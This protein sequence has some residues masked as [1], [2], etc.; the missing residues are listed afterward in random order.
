MILKKAILLVF[1]TLLIWSAF[2]QFDRSKQSYGEMWLG[3]VSKNS[4]GGFISGIYGK[5]GRKFGEKQYESFGLDFNNIKHQSEERVV[6]YSGNLWYVYRKK[7][8]LYTIVPYYGRD[9]ILFDKAAEQGIEIK[10]NL[11]AGPAI[12]LLAPYYIERLYANGNILTSYLMPYDENIKF[13]EING[14][15]G[16][17]RGIFESKLRIGAQLKTSLSFDMSTIKT[18]ASGFE[19]GF[20]LNAFA[21]DIEILANASKQ[22]L[23]PMAF[24]S[25]FY[26]LKN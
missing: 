10:L 4:T 6:G 12:G 11:S 13:I 15:G 2:G 9:F 16:M 19:V 14:P 18:Q 22:N 3:G 5:Y 21:G 24:I 20:M 17:F 7:N 25:L 1:F 26:A 23:Y 8:Y